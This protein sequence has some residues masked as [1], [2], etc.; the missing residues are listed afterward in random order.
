MG[1]FLAKPHKTVFVNIAKPEPTV[2]GLYTIEPVALQRGGTALLLAS[3]LQ[4]VY[5]RRVFSHYKVNSVIT[6]S[7][8][9]FASVAILYNGSY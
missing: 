3:S 1:L 5:K 4:A 9:L 8:L 6:V 2:A 7:S